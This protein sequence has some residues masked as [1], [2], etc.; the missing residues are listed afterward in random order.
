M[1]TS[2]IA[3]IRLSLYLDDD[4][5]AVEGADRRAFL[6][7]RSL[8]L[9]M[10]SPMSRRH[11]WVLTGLA[12]VAFLA[13]VVLAVVLNIRERQR[14]AREILNVLGT[15]E[16]S[17]ALSESMGHSASSSLKLDL[18]ARLEGDVTTL[19]ATLTNPGPRSMKDVVIEELT[20][21]KGVP[22]ERGSLPVR[23][24]ELAPGASHRLVLQFD[25][26]RWIDD[27]V[28]VDRVD[29]GWATKL[30]DYKASWVVPGETKSE[31]GRPDVTLKIADSHVSS[32]STGILVELGPE[33]ARA[34]K[35]RRDAGLERP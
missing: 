15:E 14:V 26:L 23:I 6:P 3:R 31:G 33:D 27:R 22:R 5:S 35:E 29:L 30:L 8:R 20:L 32:S 28:G 1:K 21:D 9:R 4:V 11:R 17:K 19:T 10:G 12:S 7:A 2:I 34:L 24:S 18:L 25:K 16:F 13:G